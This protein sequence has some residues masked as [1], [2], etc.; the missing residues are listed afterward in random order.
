MTFRHPRERYRPKKWPSKHAK[1]RENSYI[2]DLDSIFSMI[3]C[4]LGGT[5]VAQHLRDLKTSFLMFS[6]Q[7][8]VIWCCLEWDVQDF[9]KCLLFFY[10]NIWKI[11]NNSYYFGSNS[12]TNWSRND[13]WCPTSFVTVSVPSTT[14]GIPVF[15]HSLSDFHGTQSLWNWIEGLPL[16]PRFRDPCFPGSGSQKSE[17]SM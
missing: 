2:S 7:F 8:W 3:G 11:G 15:A 10:Q 9:R 16:G 5:I 1:S 4:I 17:L 13:N 6:G 14:F 12:V